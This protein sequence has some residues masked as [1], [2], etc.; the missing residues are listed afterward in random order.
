MKNIAIAAGALGHRAR[1]N[2]ARLWNSSI[3]YAQRQD[4][5]MLYEKV[6][7][8]YK[9]LK[10]EDVG[11]EQVVA[12]EEQ[13]QTVSSESVVADENAA[14]NGIKAKGKNE[15]QRSRF[16]KPKNRAK[17]PRNEKRDE[18][19]SDFERESRSQHKVEKRKEEVVAKQ[20]RAKPENGEFRKIKSATVP[21]SSSGEKRQE[22][23]TPG[24]TKPG[25]EKCRPVWKN[26]GQN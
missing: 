21:I 26:L 1:Q 2:L 10:P 5:G 25:A 6:G 4:M 13:E 9:L 7:Q 8:V 17:K 22:F 16:G 24:V 18:Q 3:R 23:C 11:R 12:E 15:E 14:E 20:E 19:K